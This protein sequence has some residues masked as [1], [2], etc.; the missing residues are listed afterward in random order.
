MK[1]TLRYMNVQDIPQVIAID[2]LSFDLPWSE[3]SYAY[4]IN[5]AN[6]SH[7][8]VLEKDYEAERPRG[9]LRESIGAEVKILIAGPL[10]KSRIG[11]VRIGDDV[12]RSR[13]DTLT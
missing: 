4:E 10:R 6:Y 1:L 11:Q 12:P 8:V 3:R 2:R 13:R 9:W 7:M 5:E